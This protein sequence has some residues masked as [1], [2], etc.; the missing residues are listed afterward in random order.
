MRARD[1]RN[2]PTARTS[3]ICMSGFG[4]PKTK[5]TT[6]GKKSQK[7]LLNTYLS[8]VELEETVEIVVYVKDAGSDEW[9]KT[10]ALV[11]ENNQYDAAIAIHKRTI[12]LHAK[13]LRPSFK[14]SKNLIVGF[15][16]HDDEM[17]GKAPN[18]T[19]HVK[20]EA[21][22]GLLSGWMPDPNP[23]AGSYYKPTLKDGRARP[24][25]TASN[26]RSAPGPRTRGEGKTPASD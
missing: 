20:V 5:G 4:K 6:D 12:L 9:V 15:A 3:I 8:L 18:I 14:L 24:V 10:G 11:A 25:D 1:A 16:K 19:E 7:T 23:A 21:P 17:D 13:E 22:E 2:Q 26:F